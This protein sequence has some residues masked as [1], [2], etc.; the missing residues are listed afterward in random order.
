MQ[1]DP[2]P[3]GVGVWLASEPDVEFTREAQQPER[4]TLHRLAPQNA[5][6]RWT[7]VIMHHGALVVADL[8]ALGAVVALYVGMRS[9]FIGSTLAEFALAVV[10]AG[11]VRLGEFTAALLLALVVTGNYGYGDSRRE[12]GR[13]LGAT[14]LATGLVLWAAVWTY[15]PHI[16]VG[17][18]LVVTIISFCRPVGGPCASGPPTPAVRTTR[19]HCAS[20]AVH[21]DTTRLR[22][23]PRERRLR[24]GS[25]LLV[26]GLCRFNRRDRKRRTSEPLA[27]DA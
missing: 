20:N 17:Q 25:G 2:V 18:Y 21:R 14:V 4:L 19:R 22:G 13:L 24:L 7:R 23:G 26:F 15:Q 12:P 1:V 11:G 27:W 9:G 3:G 10:P 8:M 5:R 16:V 6:H